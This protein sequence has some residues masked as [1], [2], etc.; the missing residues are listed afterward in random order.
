[1]YEYFLLYAD[2]NFTYTY[3]Y[4]NE[5]KY[6]YICLHHLHA[7][8][9][10]IYIY[11]HIYVYIYIYVFIYIYIYIYIHVT[12][13]THDTLTAWIQI[14]SKLKALFHYS[15]CISTATSPVRRLQRHCWLVWIVRKPRVRPRLRAALASERKRMSR[16]AISNLRAV[17]TRSQPIG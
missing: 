12:A 5:Y 10:H 7:T 15:P 8:Y 4:I 2:V 6:I 1:M 9:T 17:L 13:K 11:I 16:Q 3:L 14:S